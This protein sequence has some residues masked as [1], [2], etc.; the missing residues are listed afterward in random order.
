MK[1][2]RP[3]LRHPGLQPLWQGVRREW[4]MK[5]V[6]FSLMAIVG[7][8]IMWY[9]RGRS[10]FFFG[11]GLLLLLWGG[12][13]LNRLLR[14][15][16]DE[17]RLVSILKYQPD[18]V[19]WVYG[20]ITERMP[21]GLRLL[22]SATLYFKLDTGEELSVGVSQHKIKLVSRILNRVLPHATF[23]YT[24]DRARQFELDPTSLRRS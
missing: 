22:P 15:P 12:W 14:K 18:C 10:L 11:C 7:A 24:P 8:G 9:C 23:G 5:V 16:P 19:V 21:F 13:L 4:R 1:N 20:I 17:Q 3:I 2:N 6:C